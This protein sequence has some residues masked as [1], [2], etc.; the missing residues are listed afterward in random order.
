MAAVVLLGLGGMSMALL[1]DGPDWAMPRSLTWV[2][3]AFGVALGV[4]ALS[5]RIARRRPADDSR[6]E[7]TG[8]TADLVVFIGT[9]VV[10][11]VLIPLVGFFETSLL[12]ITG[13]SVYLS[14]R[15]SARLALKSAGVAL[16]V[17]VVGYVVF[18]KMLYV[19][20]PMNN[21]VGGVLQSIGL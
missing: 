13:M 12:M 14:A 19:P 3:L 5:G 4:R 9:S 10:Y 18:M 21:F 8:R 16:A 17:C 20:V 1:G 15:R 7:R 11:I 6:K 2:A